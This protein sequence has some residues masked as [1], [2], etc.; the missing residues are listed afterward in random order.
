MGV[1]LLPM[2]MENGHEMVKL[3]RE[4]REKQSSNKHE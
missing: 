2:K 4:A 3:L 1:K